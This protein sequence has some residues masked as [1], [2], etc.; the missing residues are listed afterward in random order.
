MQGRAR[1][2]GLRA[3][4]ARSDASAGGSLVA[5]RLDVQVPA[6]R[7]QTHHGRPGQWAPRWLTGEDPKAFALATTLDDDPEQVALKV[8]DHL[9]VSQSEAAGWRSSYDALNRWRSALE[10]QAILV[11]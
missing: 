8:G 3:A 10:D 2:A 1:F 9:G 7:R 11:L 6:G 5:F 4:T